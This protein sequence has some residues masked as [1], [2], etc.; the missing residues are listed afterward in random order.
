MY[1]NVSR[2]FEKVRARKNDT[3]G[4]TRLNADARCLVGWTIFFF[5]SSSFTSGPY[6]YPLRVISAITISLIFS[7]LRANSL[8]SCTPIVSRPSSAVS[9]RLFPGLPRSLFPGGF[10][11][12]TTLLIIPSFFLHH[13]CSSHWILWSSY[14]VYYWSRFHFFLKLL[15]YLLCVLYSPLYTGTCIYFVLKGPAF[16]FS[17]ASNSRATMCISIGLIIP[18]T[19]LL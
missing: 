12:N 15:Y 5:S 14:D 4:K 8:R 19:A 10:H 2:S 17:N 13:K 18:C 1:T 6:W 9:S 11:S 16:S 3:H 7:R